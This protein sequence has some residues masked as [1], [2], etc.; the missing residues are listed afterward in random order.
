MM[1]Q[2]GL[3]AN[4]KRQ[5]LQWDGVTVHMKEPISVPGQ[6]DLTSR[7]MPEVLMKN[8]E[9]VSTR[10]DTERPVKILNITYAKENLTQVSNNATQLNAEEINKLLRLLKYFEE[11]FD[12]TLEDIR[13][14]KRTN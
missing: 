5:V 10:E 9:P 7:G 2:L 11:L 8:A 1:V 14:T 4:F 6:T 12:G 13:H 3:L